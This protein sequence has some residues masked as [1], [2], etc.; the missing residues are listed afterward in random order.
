MSESL[1]GVERDALE[2]LYGGGDEVIECCSMRWVVTRFP[3]KC[4]SR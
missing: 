3:Q 2:Y 4:V 1:T